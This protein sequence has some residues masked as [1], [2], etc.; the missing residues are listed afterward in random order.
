MSKIGTFDMPKFSN[1]SCSQCG[2]DFGPGDSGFSHCQ[3]HDF[4][5]RQARGVELLR[6]S[7]DGN[8]AF[9]RFPY[10]GYIKADIA[11]MAGLRNWL[12]RKLGCL[13]DQSAPT[14]PLADGERG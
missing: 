3:D 2:E 1:V 12:E 8:E 13:Y 4:V 9:I 5:L 11:D 7:F 10:G 14:E 6:I